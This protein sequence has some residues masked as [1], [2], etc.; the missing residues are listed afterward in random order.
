MGKVVLYEHHGVTVCVDKELKGKHREHCLC[1]RCGRFHPGKPEGNCENANLL[2]A[3]C[4]KCDMVTPVYEC[5][6]FLP[7]SS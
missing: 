3:V 1:F 2:F 7:K 6:L 4:I 5:P